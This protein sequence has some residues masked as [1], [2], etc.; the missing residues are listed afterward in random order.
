MLLM[1]GV[2]LHFHVSDL[3]EVSGSR[4]RARSGRAASPRCSGS[5]SGSRS[6]GR[7]AP[8]LVLGMAL[9]VASTV[10]LMRGL[11]RTTSSSTPA[12]H[13]AVGW[14]I[15]EDILTVVVLVVIP[16]LGQARRGRRAW[17]WRRAWRIAAGQARGARRPGLRARRRGCSRGARVRGAAAL[18]R[19]V[20]ADGPG[21]R[22]RDRQPA[23]RSCSGCRWR[24]AR[25]SP[26]WSSASRRS[27]S[28]PRPTRCRCA[29]RSPCCSS[30]RSGMLFDP[31][32]LLREPLLLAGGARGRAGRQAAGG[33]RGRGAARLL[34]P[35]GAG[36]RAGARADRRVLVH[37]RRPRRATTACSRTPASACSSP[38]R[39]SRS[40]STRSCSRSLDRIEAWLRRRATLWRLLNAG[41]AARTRQRTPRPRR[42][43]RAP[44]RRSRSSSATARSA[45]RSTRRCARRAPAPWSSTSTWTRWPELNARGRHAIFGDASQPGILEQAG[46]ARASHLVVTLPHSVNRTPMIAAARQLNPTCRILVRARY[47]RERDEL[48]QV[49]D[50]GRLLRGGRG[51]RGAHLAGAGRPGQGRDGDRGARPESTEGGLATPS[52]GGVR[53]LGRDRLLKR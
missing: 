22:D 41:S 36:R 4:S 45:A 27:A 19:A 24:S 52:R 29:T 9:S 40:R 18:A 42:P 33:A 31:A 3:L 11:R 5:G 30:C 49:G 6:A 15:V 48:E 25:S 46:L 14:L 50:D 16:V 2:G 1:F 43:W 13:V 35:H 39:S 47:L 32:F 8:G 7:S 26:A 51:R 28:R 37:P 17:A 38:A 21:A 34:G 12:G 10:V 20:H 53:R 44:G 23:R